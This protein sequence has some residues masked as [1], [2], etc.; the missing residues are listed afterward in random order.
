MADSDKN[1]FDGKP[2]DDNDVLSDIEVLT[3]KYG[4]SFS[5]DKKDF[6][7]SV[8][9]KYGYDETDTSEIYSSLNSSSSWKTPQ[10][11]YDVNDPGSAVKIVYGDSNNLP[12]GPEG[13]RVIYSEN[14][15]ESIAAKRRRNAQLAARGTQGFSN[16]PYVKHV[17]G[18]TASVQKDDDN[19]FTRAYRSSKTAAAERT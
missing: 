6:I 12:S 17:A 4:L 8:S 19:A 14:E 16:Q 18:G 2:E 15:T 13:R 11:F 1:I 9:A 7:E 5:S 3:K 10:L